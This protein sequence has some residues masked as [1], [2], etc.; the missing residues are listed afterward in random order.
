V[1]F[2]EG[3]ECGQGAHEDHVGGAQVAGLDGEGIRVD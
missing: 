1:L 2:V 3:H